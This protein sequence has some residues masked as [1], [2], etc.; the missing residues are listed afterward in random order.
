MTIRL[1]SARSLL[2][3]VLL[4]TGGLVAGARSATAQDAKP[5]AAM[6]ESALALRDSVVNLARAQVG[7]KYVFGGTAPGS[8]FDCSG[9]VRYVMAALDLETPRTAQQQATLGAA[10]VKDPQRL[11]PGDLLTFS[12]PKGVISHIGIYVG[13]GRYVH[14]SSKAGQVI[15][16]P[17]RRQA[18]TLIT[19]WQGARRLMAFMDPD[20]GT[21]WKLAPNRR[22]TQPSVVARRMAPPSVFVAVFA[23]RHKV[24]PAVLFKTAPVSFAAKRAVP[25]SAQARRTA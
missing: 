24:S 17:I 18:T 19:I 20:D 25:A 5:F 23:A 4:S 1:A 13:D 9:L 16:S 21:S 11:R 10:V 12:S 22:P 3:A 14:A 6:S 15:E 8:G 7:Q 2:T